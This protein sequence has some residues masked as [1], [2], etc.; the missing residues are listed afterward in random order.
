[1]STATRSPIRA[2]DLQND[3]I[4]DHDPFEALD[5]WRESP[6]FWCEDL[7]GFWVVTRFEDCRDL[8][9]DAE[10]FASG[11]GTTVPAVELADLLL[12]SFVN[13]PYVQK[14]RAIVLPHMTPKCINA[15]EP[16]MRQVC[17]DLISSFR[18]QGSCDIIRSFARQYPIRVFSDLFG[19]PSDRQEEFRDHA[20]TFLHDW[21]RQ[22]EA[23]V[24][25]RDIVREQL[26]E[27]RKHPRDDL[28]SAIACGRIDDALIDVDSAVNLASTVFLGGLDTLPSNIGWSFRYLA[29]HPD[30]RRRIVEDPQVVPRMVEEFLRLWTVTAKE[31]RKATRDIVFKGVQMY[32]GDRVQALIGVANHDGAEFEDPLTANFDRRINRHIAFAAGPHRCLG[33]HLARHELEVALEEWHKV[34]PNYRIVP[35][36][37]LF[38]DGGGIFA[39]DNLPLEWAV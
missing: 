23:W 25:I 5:S 15:L 20:E 18:D 34:L 6:P 19:L 28:L 22:A 32:E 36:T 30:A 26:E 2:I 29:D 10:T 24:S 16:K 31:P 21:E 35:D 12:P 1:M 33:S 9:Q 39:I 38:Y 37:K 7:G 14:L 11:M 13:P 8:L 3:R 17:N 4:L 27:K